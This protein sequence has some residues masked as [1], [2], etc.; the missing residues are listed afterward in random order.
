MNE[1][2]L[3]STYISRGSHDMSTVAWIALGIV[4]Y[5]IAIAF[6]CLLAGGNNDRD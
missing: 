6:A 1:L 3:A 2:A 4:T 5:V